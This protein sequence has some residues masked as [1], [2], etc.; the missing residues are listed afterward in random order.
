[1]L[2]MQ[3]FEIHDLPWVPAFVRESVVE[4]LGTTM[5]WGGIVRAL[6]PAYRE[7]LAR[8]E[9]AEVLEL[10]SGSGETARLLLDRLSAAEP[11]SGVPRLVLTDLTPRTELWRALCAG[12]LD[13]L[14]FVP[15]RIDATSVPKELGA[16]RSR[17]I[18]N[19]FHHFTP[20]MARAILQDAYE[21]SEGIFIAENFGRNPLGTIPCGLFGI[22]A[23]FA[24][25]LLT[26]RQRLA[27]ALLTYLLPII[28]AAVVWD[29][30]VSSLRVYTDRDLL[31]MTRDLEDF[32]WRGGGFQYSAFGRGR[33]FYGVPRRP[34]R[35]RDESEGHKGS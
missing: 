11:A 28:P 6:L 16:G 34:G 24:N 32:E 15:G 12:R 2:R 21:S 31:A 3:L 17:L 1:M 4:V 29:G 14:S 23:A 30:F 27:K 9:G 19:A 5:K 18:L 22:P 33:F 8:T 7:F 10:C 26:S 25:P 13:A 20:P 35:A